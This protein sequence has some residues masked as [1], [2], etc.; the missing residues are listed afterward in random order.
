[1]DTVRNSA[2]ANDSNAILIIQLIEYSEMVGGPA[3]LPTFLW[4]GALAD[5]PD[6]I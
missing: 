5:L 6:R 3:V 1:M 4:R 2:Q